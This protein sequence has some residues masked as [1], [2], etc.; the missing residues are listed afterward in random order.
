MSRY[1][2]RSAVGLGAASLALLICAGCFFSGPRTIVPPSINGAAAGKAALEEYDTNHDGKI[3]GDELAKCPSL[4]ALASQ[5]RGEVTAEAIQDQVKQWQVTKVG[6]NSF[7]CVFLHNGKPLEGAT[8]TFEPEKFLG[9]SFPSG[10]AK[11]EA[12]GNCAPTVAVKGDEPPG[13]PYGYYKIKV[14]GENIPAKYNTE[15]ILG[16]SIA[17]AT[18]GSG[19]KYNLVY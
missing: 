9:P 12:G 8:V 17:G 2:S 4:S 7:R 10:T 1:R 18:I 3:S 15:T 5:H 14:T 6:R 13:M 16:T 19:T 11:T